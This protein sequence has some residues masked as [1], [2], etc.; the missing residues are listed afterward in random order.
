MLLGV[1]A[2]ER[3]FRRIAAW[4]DGW[5]PMGSRLLEPVF[6]DWLASLRRHCE[7][8]GRDPATVRVTALCAG[9]RVGQLPAAVE[10]AAAL[11]VER[12]LVKIDDGKADVVLPVLDRLAAAL[13][14]TLAG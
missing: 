2:S 14:K 11:G 3:N 1:P 9:M 7:A 5:I 8:V 6:D 10:R 13:E 4:A 12:V